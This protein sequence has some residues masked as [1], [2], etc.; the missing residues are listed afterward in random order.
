[1]FG[2][3]EITIKPDI[4]VIICMGLG[5]AIGVLT[6]WLASSNPRRKRPIGTFVID[7]T[8]PFDLDVY[9]DLDVPIE[10]FWDDREVYMRVRRT[11]HDSRR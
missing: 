8:D 9:L 1:M 10:R 4:L 3:Y 7:D 11:R 5:V 2:I 6:Y